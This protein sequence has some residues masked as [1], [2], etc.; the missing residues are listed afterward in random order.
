MEINELYNIIQAYSGEEG[1]VSAASLKEALSLLRDS[2]REKLPKK[3]LTALKASLSGNAL[4]LSGLLSH[5]DPG[6]RKLA[7]VVMGELSLDIFAKSLVLALH[8]EEKIYLRESYLKALSSMNYRPFISEL[9]ERLSLI[10]ESLTASGDEARNLIDEYHAV[11]DLVVSEEG[12]ELHS[13]VPSGQYEMVLT[14]DRSL[15]ELLEEE[16]AGIPKKRH[17]GGLAVKTDRFDKVF[18]CRLYKELLFI[19]PGVSVLSPDPSEAS[20]ALLDAGIVSFIEKMHDIPGPFY[21]RVE[22]RKEE[23]KAAAAFEKKLAF[24]LERRSG[25]LLVNSTSHYEMEIR[26]IKDR[27][28]RYNPLLKLFTRDDRRFSYR[29]ESVSA[30][31]QPWQGALMVAAAREHLRP[32]ARVLDPFCGVGTLL[33]ERN[34]IMKTPSLT[35]VDIFGDAIDKSKRNLKAFEQMTGEDTGRRYTF[36]TSDFEDYESNTGF[37]EIITDLPFVTGKRTIGEIDSLYQKFLKRADAMLRQGGVILM[38]T[39]HAE[40]ID[41]HLDRQNYVVLKKHRLSGNDAPW[42]YFAEK[43]QNKARRQ[44]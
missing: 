13:F 29:K 4:P 28:G 25:L 37:D 26:L 36:I 23:E 5:D 1:T 33:F 38:F 39:R 43:R 8:S 21:F 22:L 44:I 42:L 24:E 40:L 16:L 20:K 41:R 3:E 6:I 12:W 9:K 11:D 35:G 32:N 27:E 31:M 34:I 19:I 15:I 17:P 7:A 14:S 2:L 10:R 18:C 30:S